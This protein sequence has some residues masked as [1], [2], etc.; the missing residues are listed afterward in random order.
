M[1]LSQ[2]AGG[3]RDDTRRIGR[4]LLETLARM[5]HEGEGALVVLDGDGRPRGV[6]SLAAVAARL[7]ASSDVPAW[8]PALRLALHLEITLD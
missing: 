7:L 4:T 5:L 6:V 3:G 2:D 8:L 1:P